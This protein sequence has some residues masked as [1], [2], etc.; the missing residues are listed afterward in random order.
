MNR[1]SY[2]ASIDGERAKPVRRKFLTRY[3]M[4]SNDHDFTWRVMNFGL[5]PY[6]FN[7]YEDFSKHRD[8]VYAYDVF[9]FV[10]NLTS[11]VESLNLVGDMLWIEDIPKDFKHMPVSRYQW[12][13]I[14]A[15]VFLMRYVSVVDCLLLLVNSVFELNLSPEKCTRHAISSKINNV[16]IRLLLDGIYLIQSELRMERNQRLHH[17]K[18]RCF[19][20]DDTTF[21][22]A[23]H[24]NDKIH[25][26]VGNDKF[27]RP[28]DVD[29]F[30]REGL[31]NL[32]R[33]FNVS[34]KALNS[35]L[36]KIYDALYIEFFRRFDPMVKQSTHGI[37]V[38]G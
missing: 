3:F 2:H 8:C 16:D 36:G 34:T 15:D 7:S 21:E 31:V 9:D 33:D 18:E 11:R 23:S 19:T 30:F 12:L 4:P 29:K 20:Q 26:M 14:A 5:I 27:G 32:Q 22:T 17:G 1:T 24:F 38:R 13:T 35:Q 6:H 37:Y 28:I 25:E 10:T